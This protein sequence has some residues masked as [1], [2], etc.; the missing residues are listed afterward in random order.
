MV[1][2]YSF[3]LTWICH[4]DNPSSSAEARRILVIWD[5]RE[6]RGVWA[7]EMLFANTGCCLDALHPPARQGSGWLGW[8]RLALVRAEQI[9]L[10]AAL[11][12]DCEGNHG[13]QHVVLGM[14]PW[15]GATQRCQMDTWSLVMQFWM[16]LLT[17]TAALIIITV[18]FTEW[19]WEF[20]WVPLW[21]CDVFVHLSE[22]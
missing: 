17:Q 3:N 8:E 19:R 13:H 20:N 1:V 10:L 12:P 7:G 22:L 5:Q 2:S 15:A 4:F 11:I 16:D 14:C 21:W 18:M 6:I 9:C